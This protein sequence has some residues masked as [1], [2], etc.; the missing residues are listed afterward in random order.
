LRLHK[1]EPIETAL[2]MPEAHGR[3]GT[4]AALPTITCIARFMSDVLPHD[5]GWLP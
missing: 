3:P 2:E 1:P 4:P 5:A